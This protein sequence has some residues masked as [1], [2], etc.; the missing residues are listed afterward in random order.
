VHYYKQYFKESLYLLGTERRKLPGLVSL[1]LSISMLEL[2][3]LGLI[4]PYVSLAINTETAMNGFLAPLFQYFELWSSDSDLILTFL[5]LALIGIFFIKFVTSIWVNLKIIKFG[6]KQQVRLRSILM[7]AYQQLPYTEY[8]LRNSSEYIHSIH[9]RVNL[10]SSVVDVTLRVCSTSILAF[11]IIIVLA[12]NNPLILILLIF[13]FGCF[14][15]GYDK[16]FHNKISKLGKLNNI[17]GKNMV[18]AIYEGIQGLKEIRILGKSDH[19]HRRLHHSSEN[20]AFYH[21]GYTILNAIPNFLFEFLAVA[22]VVTMMLVVVAIE[23]DLN[24]FIPTMSLFALATL[25]L[26]PTASAIS[27]ALTQLRYS[28]DSISDL[29][30]DLCRIEKFET[31]PYAPASHNKHLVDSFQ[32]LSLA[33][34]S[35]RYPENNETALNNITLEIKSGDSIGLIGSSGS[36]KTTL[37]DVLL[38][39]LEPQE[40]KIHYNGRELKSSMPEL[41][42]Q[43]AYIPQQVFLIDSSIQ[44]NVALG[45]DENAIDKDRLHEA[46]RQARMLEVVEN[47]PDGAETLIGESGVRL[48]GGQRQRVALARA[49]Y[50]GRNLLI[51]DEST[52]SLD[53]ETERE[54][55]DEIY[56]LKGQKT[57][58]VIAHRLSTINNCKKIIRLERGKIVQTGPPELVL[59]PVINE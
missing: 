53:N 49:F 48:S 6:Q 28:R 50:H 32:S 16:I 55:V 39:L 40:G 52:S 42:K 1:F 13:M 36:G 34:V 23:M 31:F 17:A 46:L 33:N 37:V 43:V 4:I 24:A 54:I 18:Q 25:R 27:V 19:F 2:V 45:V 58:I 8:L 5:G 14:M 47:M 30:K 9:N 57:L 38:G 10:F 20:A 35:Y 26:K 15:F 59:Q 29:Y 51:M 12:L 44:C 22:F 7:N 56:L 3:G 11:F 21:T 41:F